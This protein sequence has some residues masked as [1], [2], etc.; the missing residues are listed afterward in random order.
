MPLDHFSVIAGLYD[1]AAEFT[2]REPLLGLLSLSSANLLLD[3]GGGTGRAAATLRPLVREA[4]VVDLSYGMLRRAAQK[5]LLAVRA[6][7]ESLPFRSGT[8][9][10][11]LIL[12]ALH[13]VLDQH[14]TANEL[15]RMLAL[16]G[17]LVIVEPDIRLLPIKLIA[18]AEK[19]LLMRSHFL[20]GEKIAALFEQLGGLVR[21]LYAENNVISLV[22]K[23]RQV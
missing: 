14:Q 22:Q 8:F 2:V 6:P 17:R 13:H 19:L 1:R 11:I 23:V 15:W 12:D 9:D 7:V 21:V 16:G 5:R 18:L 3:A 10:R 4:V 20:T